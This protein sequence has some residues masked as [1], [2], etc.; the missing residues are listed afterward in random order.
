MYLCLTFISKYEKTPWKR[1]TSPNFATI[2]VCLVIG[3]RCNEYG[4][5]VIDWNTKIECINLI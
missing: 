5:G 2:N 1:L 4:S 3:R